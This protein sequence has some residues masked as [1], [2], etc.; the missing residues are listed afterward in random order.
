M[1]ALLA[2]ARVAAPAEM[3]D[4]AIAERVLLGRLER[5]G[6]VIEEKEA[7]GK[8]A[9]SSCRC[10]APCRPCNIRYAVLLQIR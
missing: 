10:F 9:A 5:A 2:A 4:S 6:A 3:A 8:A 1:A 7:L